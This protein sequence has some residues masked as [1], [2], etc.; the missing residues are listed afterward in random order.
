MHGSAVAAKRRIVHARKVVNNQRST[1]Q[2]F[3]RASRSHGYLRGR[4]EQSGNAQGQDR[5]NSLC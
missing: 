1:M 5:P 3:H 2:Q 4:A